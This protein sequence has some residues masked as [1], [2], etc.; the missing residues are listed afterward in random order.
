MAQLIVVIRDYLDQ[1]SKAKGGMVLRTLVDQFLEIPGQPSRQAA[2]IQECIDWTN[3][4]KRTFL[5]QSLEVRLI[6][7]HL[8]SAEYQDCLALAGQL[9]K[10]LKKLDDKALLVEVKS[11][12]DGPRSFW[13]EHV[14]GSLRVWHRCCPSLPT[15]TAF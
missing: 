7:L 8:K 3:A 6:A 11:V 9:A 1:V 13:G 15:G 4:G 14:A 5:R 2:F 12:F 10:E